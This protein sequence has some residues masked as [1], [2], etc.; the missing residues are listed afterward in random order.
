MAIS[1]TG[2]EML[3]MNVA[4][5]LR[6]KTKTTRITRPMEITM[7]RWASLTEARMVVVRSFS[8][9]KLTVGGSERLELRQQRFDAVDRVDDVGVRLPADLDQHG[10]L[11]VGEPQVA[12]V[13]DRIDHAAQIRQAHRR[14]VA[15]DH[16]E[17]R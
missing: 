6:R 7:L 9:L 14:A 16:D 3:G 17:I 13:F 5:P 8:T 12:H 15:V 1:E 2:T 10:R 4:H 11:A